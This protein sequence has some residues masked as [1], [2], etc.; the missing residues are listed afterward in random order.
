MGC[1]VKWDKWTVARTPVAHHS[2]QPTW[3]AIAHTLSLSAAKPS[4]RQHQE[5][6]PAYLRMEWSYIVLQRQ[7]SEWNGIQL[8]KSPFRVQLQNCP[9]NTKLNGIQLQLCP[10][11]SLSLPRSGQVQYDS[12]SRLQKFFPS[13]DNISACNGMESSCNSAHHPAAAEILSRY[14]TSTA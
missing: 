9:R 11:G 10:S 13:A 3:A 6:T 7:I 1:D 5:T 4:K 2:V 12:I 8:Q 14:R